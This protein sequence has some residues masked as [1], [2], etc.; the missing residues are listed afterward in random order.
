M[1]FSWFPEL[2]ETKS[3]RFG[4]SLGVDKLSSIDD[5][6]VNRQLPFSFL[7]FPSIEIVNLGFG[8]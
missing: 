7:R 1:L 3:S 2:N 5:D 8:I 4:S 6:L